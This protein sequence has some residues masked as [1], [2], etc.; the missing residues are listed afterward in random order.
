[1][2]YQGNLSHKFVSIPNELL[3]RYNAYDTYNTACLADNLLRQMRAFPPAH[4]AWWND[5]ALP[6]QDA[7]IDMQAVGIRVDRKARNAYALALRRELRETDRLVEAYADE[8][9][10]AYTD[11]FLGSSKQKAEFLFDVLGLKPRKKT[12]SKKGWATDQEAL[13]RCLKQFRKK[14]EPHRDV[15]L[16]LLHRSRLAT[17]KARYLGFETDPDGRVRPVVKICGTK[18]FRYA[19]ASPALQQFPPETL[20]FFCAAPGNVLV[21][22]DHSQLEA[23]LLAIFSG[24]TPS[25]ETFA[26]GGDIHIQNTCDL[27]DLDK[28]AFAQLGNEKVAYRGAGKTFLYEISYGGEGSGENAK[29]FCP[30]PRCAHKAPPV[31][32]QTKEQ[33]LAAR[34]R[35]FA[36]HPAVSAW[37]AELLE[38]V[39][40]DH[41]YDSPFGPRRWFSAAY[42]NDLER[43][44]KNCPMQMGGACH[45]NRS[46]VR[47]HRL[48]SP[49]IMQWHDAF[50]FECPEK[51]APSVIEQAREIMEAPVPELGGQSLPT[52]VQ[53]GYN[54]GAVGPANPN[55]LTEI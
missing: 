18:T 44:A 49:I 55:G 45:M 37:Q 20:H 11:K 7:V 31:L 53:V 1:M 38:R 2:A 54:L 32:E 52:S 17:I 21:E 25:L 36:K 26:S 43:E 35:W 14:D 34:D 42:S 5:W 47:L 8:V 41:Y 28:N 33:S 6:L 48:G 22:I 9:G 23:R 4:Q 19:Y 29:I 30:C 46:Q 50:I 16:N 3:F 15:V 24:D 39:R 27:F 51:E 40:R 13:T 12:P 10:Y